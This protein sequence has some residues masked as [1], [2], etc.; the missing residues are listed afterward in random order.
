MPVQLR[1]HLRSLAEEAITVA[2]MSDVELRTLDDLHER[3]DPNVFWR[4]HRS[5]LVNMNKIRE[6]V[7]W[8]RNYILRMKDDKSTEI[9]VSRAHTRRI[10]EYLEL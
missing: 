3:L 6:I 8:F 4:V 5:H 2:T 1:H 10:R 7:P 9:P